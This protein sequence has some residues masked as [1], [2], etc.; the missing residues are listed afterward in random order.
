A[1]VLHQVGGANAPRDDHDLFRDGVSEGGTEKEAEPEPQLFD[2]ATIKHRAPPPGSL[3]RARQPPRPPII[4]FDW[5]RLEKSELE[6]TPCGGRES[7]VKGTRNGKRWRPPL[8]V[9]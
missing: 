7:P 3:G 2:Q 4:M 5:P 1:V 6:Q 8:V 9:S